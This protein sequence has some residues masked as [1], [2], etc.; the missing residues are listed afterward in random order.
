MFSLDSIR[1]SPVDPN[2]VVRSDA[3]WDHSRGA[4][5]VGIARNGNARN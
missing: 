2:R 5:E 4:N 3:N 1:G